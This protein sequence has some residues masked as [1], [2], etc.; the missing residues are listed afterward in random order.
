MVSRRVIMAAAAHSHHSRLSMRRKFTRRAVVCASSGWPTVFGWCDCNIHRSV[1]TFPLSHPIAFVGD[2]DDFFVDCRTFQFVSHSA[3]AVRSD[4]TAALY[5]A[6]GVAYGLLF[7]WLL[8][9]GRLDRPT[10]SP[11]LPSV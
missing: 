1:S 8:F 5:R 4:G 3:A 10:L 7:L 11:M 6:I 2:S 9:F